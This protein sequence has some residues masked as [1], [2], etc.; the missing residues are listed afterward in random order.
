MAVKVHYS[1]AK[2]VEIA[3]YV[4]ASIFN[5]EYT[6]VLYVMQYLNLEIGQRELKFAE[7]LDFE[8]ISIANIKPNKAKVAR[9][10]KIVA[11]KGFQRATQQ[12]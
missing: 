4:A 12:Q 3:S 5:D 2:I 10:F 9:K 8:G 11:Q 6:S 7:K 1:D